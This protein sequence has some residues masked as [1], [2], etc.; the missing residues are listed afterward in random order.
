MGKVSKILLAASLAYTV[1]IIYFSTLP[2][3]STGI[4]GINP[5]GSIVHLAAYALYS[6]LM[7]ASLSCLK[8]SSVSIRMAAVSAFV[9]SAIL[10]AVVELIQLYVPGRVCDLGDWFMDLFGAA[11]GVLAFGLVM[12]LLKTMPRKGNEDKP[13]A[14]GEDGPKDGH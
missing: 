10:G 7:M 13:K 3:T 6:V 2:G 5:V 9:E 1:V 11:V 14:A 4:G 12:V 8:S